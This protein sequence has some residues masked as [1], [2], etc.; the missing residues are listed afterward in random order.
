MHLGTL[1]TLNFFQYLLGNGFL[2]NIL[3]APLFNLH[4]KINSTKV[5]VLFLTIILLFDSNLL[6]IYMLSTCR[7]KL[8]NDRFFGGRI[9][10]ICHRNQQKKNNY[11]IPTQ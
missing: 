5:H 10:L 11:H 2:A 3:I 6:S 1:Y 9:C 4:L 8:Q 7:L